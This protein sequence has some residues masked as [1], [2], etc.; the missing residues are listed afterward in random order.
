[1]MTVAEILDLNIEASN[2]DTL[3]LM[4]NKILENQS[5]FCLECE[6]FYQWG[7]IEKKLN[8]H[9]YAEERFKNALL[10]NQEHVKSMRELGELYMQSERLHEALKLFAMVVT[11]EPTDYET[12]RN[13][14]TILLHM[15]SPYK[16]I[17]WMK[18]AKKAMCPA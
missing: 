15:H 6:V 12:W 4:R 2:H 3:V 10:L 1:M 5:L 16:A 11:I 9:H 7:K 17:E 8:M 13:G 14:S 18:M